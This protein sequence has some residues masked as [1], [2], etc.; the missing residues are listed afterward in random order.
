[1]SKDQITVCF[2]LFKLLLTIYYIIYYYQFQFIVI[3][4]Q[5]TINNG[6]DYSL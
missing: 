2:H 6:T 5:V 4:S 1:M 3:I